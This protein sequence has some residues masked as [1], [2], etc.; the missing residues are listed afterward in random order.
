MIYG[1]NYNVFTDILLKV[2]KI[3]NIES[4]QF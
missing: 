1:I 3:I 4:E 2:L